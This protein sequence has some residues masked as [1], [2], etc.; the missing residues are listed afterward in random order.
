M[1]SG[2]RRLTTDKKLRAVIVDD[3]SVVRAGLRLIFEAEDE[4]EIVG[5]AANADEALEEIRRHR[6]D[7]VFMDLTLPGVG[8]LELTRRVRREYPDTRVIV[9]TLHEE[10]QYFREAL[11]AGASAYVVKGSRP[12]DLIAAVRAVRDGGTFLDPRLTSGL[13]SDYVEQQANNAFE[14][15][16]PRE[17]EVADLIIDGSSN[18]EIALQLEISV[19][20]VQTHRSH[21]ME[22]LDLRNYGELIRYAIRHGVIDP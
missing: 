8:G 3:H 5:E 6:P 4:V 9:L 10:E 18:Q 15:L 7:I 14:G 11:R 1:S 12:E 17:R 20:T 16:S 19:T 21:I 22:K 13:V 2:S